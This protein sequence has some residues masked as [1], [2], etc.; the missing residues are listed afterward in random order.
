M[1]SKAPLPV[2]CSV[3]P[4]CPVSPSTV[5][6]STMQVASL[7]YIFHLLLERL[8]GNGLSTVIEVTIPSTAFTVPT[9]WNVFG[10]SWRLYKP[11]A[12]VSASVSIGCFGANVNEFAVVVI[13]SFNIALFGSGF[14]F[15][16]K[17]YTIGWDT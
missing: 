3:N 14:C 16:D 2:S 8:Y 9:K 5:L 13:S 11:N 12:I 17:I 1:L 7:E 4:S 6:T 15:P 10:H